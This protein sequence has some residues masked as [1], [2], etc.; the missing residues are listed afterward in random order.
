LCLH[1]NNINQEDLQMVA[2]LPN[3]LGAEF[4]ADFLVILSFWVDRDLYFEFN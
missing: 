2:A 1:Q 4:L 3:P